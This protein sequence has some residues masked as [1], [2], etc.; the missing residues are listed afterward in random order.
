MERTWLRNPFALMMMLVL[1]TF[2]LLAGCSSNEESSKESSDKGKTDDNSP[3]TLTLFDKN[4]G[5]AFDNEVAKEITKHTGVKIEIQ[6]PTGN[7]DEKLNLMLASGDLPDI[8]LMPRGSEL[9]TKYISAGAL[10]PLNDLID[11][12]GTNVK[13]MYGDTLKKTRYDDGKNYYLSN[14]YGLDNEPVFGMLMRMDLLKELGVGEKANNGQPFTS[15]EF[16]KLL[17]TFK[18]KYPTINGH[19]SIPL[20]LN[21]ENM[22]SAIATFKGMWGMKSFYEKNGK[23]RYSEKDPSYLEMM[24]YM[25]KLYREG[26]IDKEWAVNKTQLWNQKLSNGYTFAT[27][28]AYWDTGDANTI[29]KKADGAENVD[30]QF[31]A[32]KVTAPGVNP[33]KTTFGPRSSLG[34]DAIGIT[35]KNKYPEKTMKLIDFLSSEE[36]QYLLMWGIEGK[37]WDMV[38]GKH[39]PKEGFLEQYKNDEN[40]RKTTGVRKWTWFIKNGAGSDGTPYDLTNKYEKDSVATIAYKNL[41]D[42]T[43]DTAIYDNLGPA[44]GTPESLISQ[45][46]TDIINSTVPK[47]IN[48][49]SE[50]EAKARYKVM[51]KDLDKVGLEKVE[52]VINDNYQKRKELWK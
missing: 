36:G 8:V 11:K 39:K 21:A 32:Y 25:N 27:A 33:S 18:E 37:H 22:G 1:V 2:T 30:K 38:D 19:E 42:T 15:E 46:V 47:L 7:P 45:K 26:L 17:K 9:V 44:A 24:L 3:I 49:P 4:T 23:L 52:K 12:Y 31:Y 29:L 50:A 20:T 34:W 5:D 6:Q 10:I 13:Q 43:W 51:L 48:S 35:S 14:W 40:F 41:D 28:S 16:Y